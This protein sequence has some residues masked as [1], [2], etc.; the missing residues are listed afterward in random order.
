MRTFL[1]LAL[2][3]GA[4]YLWQQNEQHPAAK[5]I[6]KT[7]NDSSIE[8]TIEQ[9]NWAKHALDRAHEVAGQVKTS[10]EATQAAID[11]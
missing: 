7:L 11:R 5:K 9:H 4:L 3:V 1:L 2:T 10:R 6:E 8:Q